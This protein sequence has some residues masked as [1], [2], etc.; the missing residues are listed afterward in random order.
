[1]TLDKDE[2]ELW[3]EEDKDPALW[4]EEEYKELLDILSS[5]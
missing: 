2:S 5:K 1:M 3:P 4:S